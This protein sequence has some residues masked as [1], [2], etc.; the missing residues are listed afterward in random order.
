MFKRRDKQTMDVLD[1]L[2][3]HR[4]GQLLLVDVREDSERA[5]DSAPGSR[6]LPLAQLKQRLNELPT[7]HPDAFIYHSVAA[8][9]SRRPR[10][11]A[12]GWTPTTSRAA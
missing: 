2:A 4:A 9:P 7:D 6:H 5:N 3:G 11:G 10:R 8:L 1:A 12:Q